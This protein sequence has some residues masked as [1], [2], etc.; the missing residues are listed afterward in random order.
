MIIM[1]NPVTLLL[2]ILLFAA[3]AP[4]CTTAE[5]TEP[6]EEK[7]E[8]KETPAAVYK[9]DSQELHDEI[10]RQDSI[11]FTAYNTCDMETQT[12]YYSDSLEFFHDKGGLSTSKQETLAAIKKNICGR[13]TRELVKGS[14]EV[15]PIKD[16]GA[17]EMGRHMFHNNYEKD[18]VP[19]P[20]K[21]IIFW[22]QAG[23]KW[24][25]KKVVSLH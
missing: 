20:S 2:S 3:I 18:Q 22:Q 25:I 4:A 5:K 16:W 24:I 6:K 14:L 12:A 15:Y 21:F 17:I 19:H 11:Y 10:A 7:T 13:V 8:P 9:P 1:K 23:S